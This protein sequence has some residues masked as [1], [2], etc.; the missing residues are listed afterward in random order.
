MHLHL[1]DD[2]FLVGGF[3]FILGIV[4]ALA[5]FFEKRK[6]KAPSFSNYFCS[7]YDQSLLHDGVFEEAED[8]LAERPSRI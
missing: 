4:I 3:V 5:A 2:Q 1:T 8:S 7:E 6:A